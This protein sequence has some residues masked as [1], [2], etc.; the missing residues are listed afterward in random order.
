MLT[1][2]VTRKIFELKGDPLKMM[3]NKDYNVDHAKLLDKKSLYDFAKELY[4]KVK[5]PGI[6]FIRDR[7]LIRILQSTSILISASGA[8]LF[9][10][11]KSFSKP[12]FLSSDPI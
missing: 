7:S 12:I 5:A 10:K 8:S 2:R 6:K 9:H 4:F 11:K 3:T 1:F